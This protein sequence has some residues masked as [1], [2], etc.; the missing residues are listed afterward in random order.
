MIGY[1][2]SQQKKQLEGLEELAVFT[3]REMR[4]FSSNFHPFLLEQAHQNVA[5]ASLALKWLN[6][7]AAILDS[8][9]EITSLCTSIEG[10]SIQVSVAFVFMIKFL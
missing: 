8:C 3:S 4:I 2:G 1:M 6:E 5:K 10:I 9:Q 7:D